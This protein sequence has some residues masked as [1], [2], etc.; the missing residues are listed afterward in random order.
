M[1]VDKNLRD[2]SFSFI[3]PAAKSIATIA[4]S[5]EQT[6]RKRQVKGP[7]PFGGSN[8][9]D[10]LA[11]TAHAVSLLFYFIV[12]FNAPSKIFSPSLICSLVTFSGGIQR[13]TLSYVPQVSNNKF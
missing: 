1:L 4:Q 3:I 13:I 9:N 12:A 6:F 11:D 10:K 7:N 2:W 5:V 8:A